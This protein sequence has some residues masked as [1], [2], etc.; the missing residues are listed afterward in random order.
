[1]NEQIIEIEFWNRMSRSNSEAIIETESWNKMSKSLRR[2]Q[3]DFWNSHRS[4]DFS[5]KIHAL[6]AKIVSWTMYPDQTSS[7][8]VIQQ[9]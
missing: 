1:M 5:T 2:I 6:F 4:T 8:D 7:I 9:W 3:I